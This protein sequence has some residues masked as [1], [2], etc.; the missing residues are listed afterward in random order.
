MPNAETCNNSSGVRGLV[1]VEGAA[2]NH[3]LTLQSNAYK[4]REI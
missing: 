2:P 1:S 3:G 4:K